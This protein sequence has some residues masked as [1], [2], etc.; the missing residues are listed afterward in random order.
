MSTSILIDAGVSL[1]YFDTDCLGEFR[2]Q[3]KA[4]DVGCTE[5]VQ[6][7]NSLPKQ[8]LTKGR[9][10]RIYPN[11]FDGIIEVEIDSEAQH[12]EVVLEIYNI[13]GE[14]LQLQNVNL[15]KGKNTI[16]INL[17]NKPAGIYTIRIIKNGTMAE[18]IKCIKN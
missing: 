7:I 3:G 5:F 15:S 9:T 8:P 18:A 1:P 17:S 12:P 11:P 10:A 14:K 16:P 4:W 6:I 2:P 13:L